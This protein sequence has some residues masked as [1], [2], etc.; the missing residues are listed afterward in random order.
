MSKDYL[1]SPAYLY[2][3]CPYCGIPILLESISF[4][5]TTNSD[6]SVDVHVSIE[7]EILHLHVIACVKRVLFGR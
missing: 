7:S 2:L 1:A 3:D 6:D 4:D 5:N